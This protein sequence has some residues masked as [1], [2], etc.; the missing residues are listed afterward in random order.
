M[1]GLLVSPVPAQTRITDATGRT[2]TVPD[3]IRKVYAAGPP[4][5]VFVLALAPEKLAGWTRALRPDEIPFLPPEVARLPDLG[6]LTG[7]GNTVNAEGVTAAKPDVVVDIGSTAPPYVALAERVQ[8]TTGIPYLLFDGSLRDTPRLL[9]QLGRIIDA[10][11]GRTG[12]MTHSC[13]EDDA[14]RRGKIVA[15]QRGRVLAHFG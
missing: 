11:S 9:R 14:S 13:I 4:A 15:A 5:S 3:P 7:H 1:V 6:R 12:E 8:Q 2:L 10:G